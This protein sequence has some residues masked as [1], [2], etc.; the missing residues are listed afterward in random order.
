MRWVGHVASIG[1]NGGI[2]RVLVA[3]P[4]GKKPPGR[5]R[6]RW[7]DN[8]KMDLQEVGCEGIDWIDVVQDRDR[9]RALLNAVM[10]IWVP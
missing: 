3:K 6:Y 1:E 5:P 9:W 2:L 10:N 7:K 8:M 4:A